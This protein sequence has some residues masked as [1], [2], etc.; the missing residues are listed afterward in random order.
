[1]LLC[2]NT[3]VLTFPGS[4]PSSEFFGLNTSVFQPDS[5]YKLCFLTTKDHTFI[6]HSLVAFSD[7]GSTPVSISLQYIKKKKK[8]PA[9]GINNNWLKKSICWAGKCAPDGCGA[10]CAGEIRKCSPPC[11]TCFS[12]HLKCRL[13]PSLCISVKPVKCQIS[14]GATGAFLC[15]VLETTG[16]KLVFL[17]PSYIDVSFTHSQVMESWN[18]RRLHSMN[19][20]Q[21]LFLCC[22]FVFFL[23]YCPKLYLRFMLKVPKALAASRVLCC[24]LFVLG[25]IWDTIQKI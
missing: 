12:V 11:L 7:S 4:L 16:L 24:V 20:D 21:S 3:L 9:R 8:S 17:L 6:L 2:S 23:F 25:S 15:S 1:M 10:S 14:P 22:F 13:T 18:D 5:W 19:I